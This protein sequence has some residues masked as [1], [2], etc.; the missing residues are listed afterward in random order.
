MSPGLR[1][2]L[3]LGMA[4][5]LG[6]PVAVGDEV[7]ARDEVARLVRQ[8]GSGD[9][10]EREA[11][12]KALDTLGLLGLDALDLAA[13]DQDPEVRKRAWLLLDAIEKRCY[14]GP[15]LVGGKRLPD[16]R[17]RLGSQDMKVRIGA[18]NEL[19]L[20]QSP[21][22]RFLPALRRVIAADPDEIVRREAIRSIRNYGPAALPAL[23]ALR[24]AL[25]DPSKTVRAAAAQII[26]IVAGRADL[27]VPALIA[28]LPVKEAALRRQVADS[29]GRMGPYA[30]E[31]I[32]ALTKTLA[33]VES[34]SR[35]AVALALW[36]IDRQNE[37]AR[38]FFLDHFAS[39]ANLIERRDA[40]RYLVNSLPLPERLVP[41]LIK[42]SADPTQAFRAVAIHALPGLDELQPEGLRT[43]LAALGDTDDFTRAG[44]ARALGELAPT[45]AEV[46]RALAKMVAEDRKPYNQSVA[47]AV[48]ERGG[49]LSRE[50]LPALRLALKQSPG[51]SWAVR[52]I[53]RLGSNAKAAVPDLIDLLKAKNHRGTAADALGRI[54]PD[55]AAA[56]PALIDNLN[57]NLAAPPI[58]NALARIGPAAVDPL[59]KALHHPNAGVA[60]RSASALGRIGA[61]AAVP[62]A[63]VVTEGNPTTRRL[64]ASALA[65]MGLEAKETFP[66]LLAGLRDE[67]PAV[68]GV[69]VRALGRIDPLHRDVF[70]ALVKLVADPDPANQ[71]GAVEML[72]DLGPRGRAALPA[73]TAALT[74]ARPGL[75][76]RLAEAILRIA[77]DSPQGLPVL[78]D[79]VK[80]TEPGSD[81]AVAWMVLARLGRRATPAL[82]VLSETFANQ[83]S[84]RG[85]AFHALIELCP[86]VEDFSPEVVAGIGLALRTLGL[87][88]PEDS[89]I[90][91]ARVVGQLGSRGK[92][93]L[94]VLVEALRSPDR[95]IRPAMALALWQIDRSP[96]AIPAL[97]ENLICG[98][99]ET[100]ARAATALGEIG[101][102]ARVAIPALVGVCASGEF[103][104]AHMVRP[105]ALRAL[106][107]IDPATRAWLLP[108]LLES[109]RD[110]NH[111]VTRAQV[112]GTLGEFGTAARVAIPPLRRAMRSPEEAIRLAASEALA[113]IE[114]RQE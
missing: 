37:A 78:L 76:P 62:L 2:C 61:K 100:R 66:Q 47:L 99:R 20:M 105:A 95:R 49:P 53:G 63:R 13:L 10:D 44:A 86:H 7:P 79:A 111:P 91:M 22:E 33:E 8:L 45:N 29:L 112:I 16:W 87:S 26:W 81:Q 57:D 59:V 113:K 3:L 90:Q 72:R 42:T 58:I 24:G 75:R 11:A 30:R 114:P 46:I 31:A 64:A 80:P 106:G 15:V 70:P 6:S 85:Y 9:Y 34:P 54:G 41:V 97:V 84:V 14:G 48:L 88:A 52:A 36:Q 28:L 107:K 18:L 27:A 94:G 35:F 60:A 38:A 32:P 109:L 101:P 5:N 110:V 50:L 1:F 83:T 77:P 103:M 92:P 108:I 93:M 67:D 4:A 73:L 68:R 40:L 39:D 19:L 21:V 71:D 23:T 12:S 65:E 51:Q 69:C 104:D 102:E 74:G 25:R 82:A 43:L 55:A 98:E 56:V 17:R 89:R 96:L